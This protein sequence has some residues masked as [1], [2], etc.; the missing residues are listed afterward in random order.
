MLFSLQK[1][2]VVRL[3]LSD[4]YRNEGSYF[5]DGTEVIDYEKTVDDYGS[6]PTRFKFPEFPLHYFSEVVTHNSYVW[7]PD[8]FQKQVAT[9]LAYGL[10]P[11]V[12]VPVPWGWHG[13]ESTIKTRRLGKVYYSWFVYGEQ[14]YWV[15]GA[16]P[17][18]MG[19]C[20]AHRSLFL[21]NQ[22]LSFADEYGSKYIVADAYKE[23][24][25]WK[26]CESEC[27]CERL[28]SW[29]SDPQPCS[30]AF[31]DCDWSVN[32]CSGEHG[33]GGCQ[34]WANAIAE[35]W[36]P[37]REVLTILQVEPADIIASLVASYAC[38]S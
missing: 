25:I 21:Q 27:C 26:Y 2:D 28:C 32:C 18:D 7:I 31:E 33:C 13:G 23:V 10:L 24:A 29:A 36:A 35:T 20:G 30:I 11:R 19:D 9:N 17:M 4:G 5:W 8:E 14:K 37:L 38:E 34:N 6:V 12:L 22:Y 15:I 3:H 16:G 1:G